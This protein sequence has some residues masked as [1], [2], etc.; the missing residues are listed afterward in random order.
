MKKSIIALAAFMGLGCTT[1][2]HAN[3][4]PQSTAWNQISSTAPTS[5]SNGATVTNSGPYP[6]PTVSRTWIWQGNGVPTTCGL[7]LDFN[8]SLGEVFIGY[9]HDGG[10]AVSDSFGGFDSSFL[11][12]NDA[13]NFEQSN[14]VATWPPGRSAKTLTVHLA[15]SLSPG[16]TVSDTAYVDSR[17]YV[18]AAVGSYANSSTSQLTGFSLT[19]P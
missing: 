15:E 9:Q 14:G 17:T 18:R 19:Q 4:V 1:Q 6:L 16:Q 13:H 12:G 10:V 7:Q 11:E 2:A 5:T 3:Y 8:L